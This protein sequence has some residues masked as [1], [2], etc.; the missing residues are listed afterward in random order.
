M[1]VASCANCLFCKIIKGSI[2]AHKVFENDK[3]IAFLDIFPIAKGHCLVIPKYHAAKLHEIPPEEMSEIGPALT[4][5]ARAI[6]APN[7]NI[8]QNNG[9]IAHQVVEHIHFHVIPKWDEETG[10][11]LVWNSSKAD[12]KALAELAEKIKSNF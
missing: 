3:V 4:K 5:V 7:Y 6:G 10:L 12:D 9:A 2:P 8:L 1:S 11:G